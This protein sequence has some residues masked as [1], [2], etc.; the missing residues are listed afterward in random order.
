MSHRVWSLLVHNSV[1]PL[2]IVYHFL[3]ATLF[4]GKVLTVRAYQFLVTALEKKTPESFVAWM[5]YGWG[6]GRAHGRAI[7]RSSHKFDHGL[8]IM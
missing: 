4:K 8:T 1:L 2:N 3:I 6:E 5:V 7:R